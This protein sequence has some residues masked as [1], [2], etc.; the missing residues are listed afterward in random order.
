MGACTAPTSSPQTSAA[1]SIGRATTYTLMMVASVVRQ[2]ER[3]VADVAAATARPLVLAV[4]GGL[5]SMALLEAAARIARR[6]VAVVASF[7]HGS[8]PHATHAVSFVCRQAALRQLPAVVGHAGEIMGDE[9]A[10]REARWEFLRSVARCVDGVVVT[11][12]T[13]DDQVETVLM[14]AMRGAG[15]RGLAALYARR[16]DV[17]R[18]FVRVRRPVLE[19]YLAVRRVPWIEDPT[20][21]NRR[22]FRNRV[23]HELLPALVAARPGFDDEL[24]RLAQRAAVLRG[25]ADAVVAGIAR[26]VASHAVGV[27]AAADPYGVALSVATADLAGYDAASLGVL[28]PALAARVGVALDWRGTERAVA[29]TMT[30]GR[31]GA[32]IQLAGGWEIVRDRRLF[33]LRRGRRETPNP[34][35]LP[36]AGALRWGRWSFVREERASATGAWRAVLPSERPL[37]VRAWRPGDRMAGPSGT[38]RRVKRFFGDAG[39]VGPERVGWPVVLAGEEIVW[40]PGVGRGAAARESSGTRGLIYSCEL[41]DR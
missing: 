3:C 12:H 15:A 31:A 27:G 5:D 11:A 17:E 36:P 35:D 29:F 26:D 7:D 34:A 6:R 2:I 41:N 25:E 37:V 19:R 23:R 4:S 32:S 18:P 1:D 39:I 14:R 30:R 40:I 16:A 22:Y 10:W 28:W 38:P 13:E 9:A 8:G 21:T 24:L 20:N 33:T